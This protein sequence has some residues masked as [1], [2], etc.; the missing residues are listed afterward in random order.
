MQADLPNTGKGQSEQSTLKHTIG[1]LGD[2]FNKCM[3]DWT[4]VSAGTLAYNL[5]LA[6]LPIIIAIIA[7]LGFIAGSLGYDARTNVINAF[8][9]IFP[10][11]TANPILQSA[12]HSLSQSSGWLAIIAICLAI[13]GG[14]Q[15]FISIE[16]CFDIAYRTHPR[17]MIAQP[18]MAILMMVLFIIL[19]PLMVATS[20]I[21]GFI[22]S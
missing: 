6:I 5:M 15:L 2:F 10:N 8:K 9:H 19:I 4:M 1:T 18:V 12:A 11:G 20:A 14:A 21:P 16:N 13:Y 17:G 7:G 3:N 22:S